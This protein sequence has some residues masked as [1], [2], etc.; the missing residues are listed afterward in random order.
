MN[1]KPKKSVTTLL[2]QFNNDCQASLNDMVAIHLIETNFREKQI[3][4]KWIQPIHEMNNYLDKG[5]KAI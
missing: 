2:K 4:M 1:V 5:I 3:I